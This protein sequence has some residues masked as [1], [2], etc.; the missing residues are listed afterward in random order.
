MPLGTNRYVTLV[1]SQV[2]AL[3]PVSERLQ[4][5]DCL[6]G[7]PVGQQLQSRT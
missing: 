6:A 1:P 7:R 4:P 3:M 2:A 5:D